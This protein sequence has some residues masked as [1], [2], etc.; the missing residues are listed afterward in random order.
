MFF[1]LCVDMEVAKS[2]F[3]W[4]QKNAQDTQTD[5]VSHCY[6]SALLCGYLFTKW[7]KLYCVYKCTLPHTQ[8]MWEEEKCTFLPRVV[9]VQG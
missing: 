3:L 6:S 9:W 2:Y 7:P 8:A 4:W 1:I 5:T